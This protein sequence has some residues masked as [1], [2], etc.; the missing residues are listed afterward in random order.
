MIVQL[1]RRPRDRRV[2][3]PL[4]KGRKLLEPQEP[5]EL[6]HGAHAPD[7]R[8]VDAK[9]LDHA[10][11]GRRAA[12]AVRT[13][14]RLRRIMQQAVVV[15]VVFTSALALGGEEGDCVRSKIVV[16]KRA[17]SATFQ[18]GRFIMSELMW[19]RTGM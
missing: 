10:Q 7:A 5:A 9:R 16:G 18:S 11:G 1:A 6:V 3:I 15:V 17:V 14:C 2:G 12:G 8:L 4:L 19:A 13:G